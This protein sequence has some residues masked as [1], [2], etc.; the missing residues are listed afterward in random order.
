MLI[1]EIT[2]IRKENLP[3]SR[4]SSISEKASIISRMAKMG[5]SILPKRSLSSATDSED[6]EVFIITITLNI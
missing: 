1:I 2:D 5:Q 3:V 4:T 6:T